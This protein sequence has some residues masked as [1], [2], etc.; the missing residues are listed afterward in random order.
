MGQPDSQLSQSLP[1]LALGLRGCLPRGLKY[2][3]RV[4][5]PTL[6]QESLSLRQAVAR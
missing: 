2:L 5:G 6:I 1:Q 3:V 4:K